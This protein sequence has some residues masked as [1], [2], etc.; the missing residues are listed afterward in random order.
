MNIYE[1]IDYIF[2]NYLDVN[3]GYSEEEIEHEI[4]EELKDEDFKNQLYDEIAKTKS[5]TKFS[6][7]LKFQEF[8]VRYFETEEEA[9]NYARRIFGF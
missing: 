9:N 3:V 7:R 2:A 1:S 4:H 6:W 5:D 8:N